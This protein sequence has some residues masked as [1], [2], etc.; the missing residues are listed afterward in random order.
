M[1]N[2]FEW[3]PYIMEDKYKFTQ[4]LQFKKDESIKIENVTNKIYDLI[5]NEEEYESNHLISEVQEQIKEFGSFNEL[6]DFIFKYNIGFKLRNIDGYKSKYDNLFEEF[7]NST[8]KS[9][10]NKGKF[11]PLV[12][13]HKKGYEDDE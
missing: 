7:R 6:Q 4:L 13:L 12:N 1:Y 11:K 10:I 2:K 5:H 8:T 3:L 9:A